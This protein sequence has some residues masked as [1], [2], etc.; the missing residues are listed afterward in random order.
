MGDYQDEFEMIG[1]M[2]NGEHVRKTC[3]SF[4]N[5]IVFE[6]YI[7][8]IDMVFDSEDSN[9]TGGFYKLDTPLFNMINKSNFGKRVDF[10]Q[11]II[12]DKGNNCYMPSEGYRF[13]K[14][15]NY[16]TG[17]DYMES[18]LQFIRNEKRRSKVMTRAGFQPCCQA[19]NVNIG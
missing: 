11:K 18:L 4:R 15:I 14:S 8:A 10:K 17:L 3:V 13:I 16:L 19:I 1:D 9:F 12:E 7:K 5:I 6:P 2:I